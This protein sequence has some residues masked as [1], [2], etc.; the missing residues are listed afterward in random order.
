MTY[1]CRREPQD[2]QN[3]GTSFPTDRTHAVRGHP[4]GTQNA[5]IPASARG[6]GDVERPHL[7]V[8]PNEVRHLWA[9]DAALKPFELPRPSG[10]A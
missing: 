9:R 8:M 7:N 10:S 1:D 3:D 2:R 4:V 6:I 5:V